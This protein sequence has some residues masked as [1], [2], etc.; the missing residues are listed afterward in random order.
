MNSRPQV[1]AVFLGAAAALVIGLPSDAE[2]PVP[3]ARN[4]VNAA[5]KMLEPSPPVRRRFIGLDR[6]QAEAGLPADVSIAA[7][8]SRV[9]QAANSALRLSAPN[10]GAAVEKSLADF[11]DVAGTAQV[12]QPKVFFDRI[13][14]R[15]L[16]AAISVDPAAR[17]SAV[18]LAFTLDFADLDDLD[19]KQ[20]SGDPAS[21]CTHRFD[22]RFG[23][24]AAAFAGSL[25]LGQNESWVALAADNFRYDNGNFRVATL[26]AI[27]KLKLNTFTSG[28]CP[29]LET[30]RFQVPKNADGELAFALQPAQHYTNSIVA[31]RALYL[32]SSRALSASSNAYDL[33]RLEGSDV[34]SLTL[35]HERLAGN[36]VYSQP[37]DAPQKNGPDLD[38]GDTRITQAAYRGDT[39]WAVHATACRLGK[40]P[41]E[42]CLRLIGIRPGAEKAELIHQENLGR[43]N[44]FLWAPGVAVNFYGDVLVP[45][46][47]STAKQFFAAGYAVRRAAK[48]SFDALRSLSGG[49]CALG[50]GGRRLTTVAAGAQADP[51][52]PLGF[53]VAGEYADA[54]DGL[55]CDWSTRVGLARDDDPPREPPVVL[56]GGNFALPSSQGPGTPNFNF[57]VRIDTNLTQ[58][59]PG[60]V[61][62]RLLVLS[63]R[64]SGRPSQ[65]CQGASHPI[66]GCASIDW[67][68]T[69]PNSANSNWLSLVLGGERRILYLTE[70][71]D[72]WPAPDPMKPG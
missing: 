40:P 53:W 10:G 12:S 37:F 9:L 31:G 7:S 18:H 28:P 48:G 59:D 21:W 47:R 68:L 57:P 64:D 6:T 33:W 14:D 71:R 60:T 61:A 42:N 1:F 29:D 72:L 39:L 16:A 20:V 66:N 41:D 51:L 54:L 44:L 38:T 15:F 17:E 35:T 4:G 22:V 24:G 3:T 27:D 52:D 58:A 5:S 43:R 69:A 63:L 34:D 23:A 67:P 2:P 19:V 32:L 30:R 45:F 56:A 50:A 26:F 55:G 70:S 11:F 25:A 36:F 8:S 62:G 65:T 46:Q 49:R 13:S